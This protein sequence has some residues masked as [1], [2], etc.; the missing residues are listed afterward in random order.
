[1]TVAV[2]RKIVWH[3]SSLCADGQCVEVA[4]DDSYSYV[5][6]AKA[7]DKAVLRFPHGAWVAFIASV[8]LGEFDQL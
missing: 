5:R 6:D 8:K 4:A 3:R 7:P 1:M 2:D